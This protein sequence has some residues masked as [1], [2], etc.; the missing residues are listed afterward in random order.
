MCG[1]LLST[2]WQLILVILTSSLQ[3]V[4]VRPIA[5][6]NVLYSTPRRITG[7]TLM[8]LQDDQSQPQ[9][10]TKVTI[11]SNEGEQKSSVADN[12]QQAVQEAAAGSQ[13]KTSVE[14]P[15]PDT[16]VF[17]SGQQPRNMNNPGVNNGEPQVSV[18]PDSVIPIPGS[19][20]ERVQSGV[21]SSS[22]QSPPMQTV[23][24]NQVQTLVLVP[25]QSEQDV[26]PLVLLNLKEILG[27]TDDTG[28]YAGSPPE[29]S[30]VFAGIA[31]SFDEYATCPMQSLAEQSCPFDDGHSNYS[32]VTE[33]Y[34]LLAGSCNRFDLNYF[35]MYHYSSPLDDC[36]NNLQ[37][38][39][40]DP[41]GRIVVEYC[42]CNKKFKC[43]DTFAVL[44]PQKGN[45][46]T[47][48]FA[49]CDIRLNVESVPC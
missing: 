8:Q 12:N 21:S 1:L 30:S 18:Q 22:Q 44:G 9:T 39:W 37:R 7:M 36:C 19:Q 41:K 46:F 10:E 11:A 16:S 47:E 40:N 33:Y 45:S 48:L 20:S 38:L 3:T 29:E 4:S 27:Q 43:A 13:G 6:P 26:K 49:R 28:D 32:N 17:T 23:I 34:H 25:Q 15:E 2:K 5:I 42:T 24:D 31:R 35:A 14:P